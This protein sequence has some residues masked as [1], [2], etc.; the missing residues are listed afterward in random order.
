NQDL[1]SVVENLR[2][3][4]Q[5]LDADGNILA[6]NTE[7]VSVTGYNSEEMINNPKSMERLYPVKEYRERKLNEWRE[8][9]GD[10]RDFEWTLTCKNGATRTILWSSF[11]QFDPSGHWI[12]W[13]TGTDITET[14]E[15]EAH[16]LILKKDMEIPP[17]PETGIPELRG[18]QGT[19]WPTQALKEANLG[20]WDWNPQT[21]DVI[22]EDGMAP[23]SID[24]NSESMG[25][26]TTWNEVLHP[27][28]FSRFL[29]KINSYLER[30]TPLFEMEH[31]VQFSPAE[32][33]W[34]L[35]RSGAIQSDADGMPVRVVGIHWDITERKLREEVLLQ[36]KIDTDKDNEELEK[37]VGNANRLAT[38][39]EYAEIAKVEFLSKIGREIHY[40]VDTII[41]MSGFLLDAELT[42][43]QNKYVEAIRSSGDNLQRIIHDILDFSKKDVHRLD[44]DIIDFDL[45]ATLESMNGIISFKAH[46]KCVGYNY[47]IFPEVPS[48]VQGDPGR[49]RQILINLIDYVM[50]YTS[51]GDVDVY[52]TLMEESEDIANIRFS[53]V[54]NGIPPQNTSCLNK[55]LEPSSQEVNVMQALESQVEIPKRLI[56]M[57][58]GTLG[59]EKTE[60]GERG[61]WFTAVLA[62]Q[63]ADCTC[64][65][66]SEDLRGKRILVVDGNDL[67]RRIIIS[68]L[69]AWKYRFEEA[70]DGVTALH[71]L[72]TAAEAGKPFHAVIVDKI[73]PGIDG[74]TLGQKIKE[75]AALKDTAL[76]LMTSFGRRGDA[77]HFE[78]KGFAAYLTKP[79]RQSQLYDCLAIVLNRQAGHGLCGRKIAT[80]HSIAEVRRRTTRILISEDEPAAAH[81][82]STTLMVMGY[83]TKSVVDGGQVIEELRSTAYDL[84]IID[85]DSLEYDGFSVSRDIR[86]TSY[87]VIN[88]QIP[89]VAVTMRSRQ[90]IRSK[91][92][93]AGMNGY[94]LKPVKQQALSEIIEKWYQHVADDNSDSIIEAA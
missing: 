5:A 49:L 25:R 24:S 38:E 47:T 92:I 55:I 79:I 76:I 60:L 6:W 8:C 17:A 82:V 21:G 15:A 45:C 31:R 23:A 26:V 70:R 80:R 63:A 48:L 39:A 77:S 7:C 10:C 62:K 57:M 71:E 90:E 51:E 81:S 75:T 59:L 42:P 11:A 66:I 68:L 73:I 43:V 78:N 2:V 88:H 46:E 64:D 30:R 27:N 20:W 33:R 67:N 14:N 91:C 74:E 37:A 41:G 18:R 50:S 44:L 72:K 4:I 32:T 40:P 9:R 56:K 93:Q 19:N 12:A 85:V 83:K 36:A 16:A 29:K 54:S 58:G 52:V 84:V 87:G 35:T 89:I 65:S 53:I 34:W 69:N 61:V 13:C 86:N 28:D 1:G 22:L 94:L 3:M